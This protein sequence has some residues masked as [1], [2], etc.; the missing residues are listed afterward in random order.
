MLQENLIFLWLNP[1]NHKV[2]LKNGNIN[3]FWCSFRTKKTLMNTVFVALTIIFAAS[4]F[5]NFKEF[6]RLRKQISLGY[7]TQIRL[8]LLKPVDGLGLLVGI[9]AITVGAIKYIAFEN[10]Y[11]LLFW[12]SFGATV[13]IS[14][15]LRPG[16]TLLISGEGIGNKKITPWNEV[17]YM[18]F[19]KENLNLF[20]FKTKKREYPFKLKDESMR[21]EVNQL[22]KKYS[23]ENY[24]KYFNKK[25]TS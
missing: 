19:G 9:I 22:L 5:V 17:V 2:F 16:E 6:F 7:A 25:E 14:F 23:E 24:N 8:K 21:I 12:S 13:I 3:Y 20:V 10:I 15:V 18:T 4:L 1:I 11:E